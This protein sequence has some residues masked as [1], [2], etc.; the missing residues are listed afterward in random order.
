MSKEV[1]VEGNEV[2]TLEIDLYD[3]SKHL[4]ESDKNTMK[5]LLLKDIKRFL[6]TKEAGD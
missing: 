4:S 1:E 5:S 2:N 6:E 3:W